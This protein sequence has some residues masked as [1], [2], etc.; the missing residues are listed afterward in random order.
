MTSEYH[1]RMTFKEIKAKQKNQ[2]FEFRYVEQIAVVCSY[3]IFAFGLTFIDLRGLNHLHP[4]CN[5]LMSS[6]PT[7]I[8]RSE[9]NVRSSVENVWKPRCI[10]RRRSFNLESS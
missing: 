4:L 7:Q 8:K 6:F 1:R 2:Y 9:G 3:A 10:S 5:F